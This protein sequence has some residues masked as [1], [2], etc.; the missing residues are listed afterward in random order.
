MGGLGRL[1]RALKGYWCL[2]GPDHPKLG[3]TF[4]RFDVNCSLQR[5][6]KK[7]QA[8][9]T[10]LIDVTTEETRVKSEIFCI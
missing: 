9:N 5:M 3:I 4:A 8:D 10:Q 2:Q 1:L 6:Q 7:S